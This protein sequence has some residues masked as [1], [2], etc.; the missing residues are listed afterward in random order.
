MLR[1]V[2]RLLGVEKLMKWKDEGLA[3]GRESVQTKEIKIDYMVP[4]MIRTHHEVTEHMSEEEAKLYQKNQ[5]PI[6]A[7]NIEQAHRKL[8]LLM[9]QIRRLNVNGAIDQMKFSHKVVAKTIE[10]ALI[11]GKDRAVKNFGM[12]PDRIYVERAW[13]GQGEHIKS[14]QYKAKKRYG[15]MKLQRTHIYFVL[16]E[17]PTFHYDPFVHH[18]R[19]QKV[20]TDKILRN[21]KKRTFRP[22]YLP[23]GGMKDM[24]R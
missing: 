19:Q 11:F 18:M 8:D 10:N 12:H 21:L 9:R 22:L 16:K 17:D 2:K 23:G 13:T 7:K 3:R 1:N 24:R 6:N 15:V 14:L 5:Q 20:W 4:P